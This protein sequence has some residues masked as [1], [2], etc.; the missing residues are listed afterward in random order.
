[1]ELQIGDRVRASIYPKPVTGLVTKIVGR[2]IFIN[3]YDDAGVQLCVDVK[4]CRL[5][6]N[7]V[8][9]GYVTKTH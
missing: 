6:P 4:A 2:C 1:M 8:N 9:I 5:I 3:S 7:L